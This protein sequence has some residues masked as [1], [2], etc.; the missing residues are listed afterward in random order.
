MN[1]INLDE[2]RPLDTIASFD[3][4]KD[5]R[6]RAMVCLTEASQDFLDNHNTTI[7]RAD[8]LKKIISE[9]FWFLEECADDLP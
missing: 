8:E 4:C 3:L 2:E 6:G 1:I 9:G 7:A 5:Y